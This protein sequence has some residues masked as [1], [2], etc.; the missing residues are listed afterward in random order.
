MTLRE[1]SRAR[2]QA[3]EFAERKAETLANWDKLVADTERLIRSGDIESADS[4]LNRLSYSSGDEQGKVQQVRDLSDKLYE[5][6]A[7]RDKEEVER[8]KGILIRREWEDRCASVCYA[9]RA[10]CFSQHGPAMCGDIA[11]A[12]NICFR[13]CLAGQ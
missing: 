4:I 3:K 10:R 12:G 13:R 1:G 11:A 8:T 2:E 7:Q 6:R 5:A 9:E